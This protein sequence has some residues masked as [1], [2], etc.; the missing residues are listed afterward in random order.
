MKG[1]SFG[2]IAEEVSAGVGQTW[3]RYPVYGATR[4]GLAPAKEKVGKHPHRY[5]LI[6]PGTVFYNP[7]RIAIGSIALLDEGGQP[8]ITSPDYVVVRPK[9]GK[10]HYRWFYYW[11][12]S[13]AGARFI[14]S[15]K[16]G[17]VRERILFSRLASAEVDFP[18]WAEQ[19]KIA[20]ALKEVDA[21]K[22]AIAEQ[23]SQLDQLATK[24][25]GGE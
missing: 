18:P 19:I 24:L 2:E 4:D 23:V 3:D 13:P 5:K 17:A 25:V 11:F 6:S 14:E 1:V 8:G 20:A 15:L 12:R 7:M 10:L 16:R 21:A 22:K 9:V